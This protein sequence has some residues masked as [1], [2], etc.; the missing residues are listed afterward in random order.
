MAPQV[1]TPQQAAQDYITRLRSRQPELFKA[2]SVRIKIASLEDALKIAFE[3]GHR[4]EASRPS[5]FNSL[6]GNLPKQ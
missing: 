2:F 4:W 5:P 3:A 6:F 1:T